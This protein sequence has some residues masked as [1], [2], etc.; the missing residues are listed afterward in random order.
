MNE[1]DPV[2]PLP[3]DGANV[4][5]MIH[6]FGEVVDAIEDGQFETPAPERLKQSEFGN[7]A[8]GNR[9]CGNCDA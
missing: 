7:K 2:V 8:F 1:W 3:F 4:E 5:E 6:E 9:V